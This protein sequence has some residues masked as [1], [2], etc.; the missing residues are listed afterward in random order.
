MSNQTFSPKIESNQ[1]IAQIFQVG[2]KQSKNCPW[3]PLKGRVWPK[4]FFIF[5]SIH[6][7]VQFGWCSHSW[8]C[9]RSRR[10]GRSTSPKELLHF[11]LRWKIEVPSLY[12]DIGRSTPS[13]GFFYSAVLGWQIV[14]LYKQDQI[15]L[16]RSARWSC[17]V[18]CVLCTVGEV[19]WA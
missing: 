12:G 18:F 19:A 16:E 3:P 11:V 1:S 8:R 9:W 10:S 7:V 15:G 6:L 5:L 13:M 2:P 14:I 4:F 17:S